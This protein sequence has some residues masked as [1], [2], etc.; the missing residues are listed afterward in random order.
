MVLSGW[1]EKTVHY[2]IIA[3]FSMDT[4]LHGF[5]ISL[6]DPDPI[7]RHGISFSLSSDKTRKGDLYHQLAQAAEDSIE[8]EG[9]FPTS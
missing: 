8:A 5:P 9:H 6:S 1:T 3:D 7:W 2:R 4:L